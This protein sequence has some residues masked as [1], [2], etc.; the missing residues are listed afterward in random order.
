MINNAHFD[1][2]GKRKIWYAISV[3]VIIAGIISL[4]IQGLN[5]GLDFTGGNVIQIQF[6]E[7]VA[8]D[9]LRDV[10]NKY[11]DS[12]PTIQESDDNNYIIRT[13]EMDEETSNA[14]LEEIKSTFGNDE[15]LRNEKVGAVIGSELI[16]NA[17]WALIAAVILMLIYITVRFKFNFA[18]SAVVPLLHDVLITVGLFSILRVE[19]DSTFVAAILT[20]LGYS[21]NG[22][23]VIFDRIRE[24]MSKSAKTAFPELVNN[25]INQTLGRSINTNIAVLILVVCLLVLGGESTKSFALALLIGF[26]AGCYSSMFI[27]GPMLSDITHLTGGDK[28]YKVK[29]KK[30]KAIK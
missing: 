29:N 21:I 11:V 9:E 15:I 3:V 1:F 23:I 8:I 17:K 22:T 26:V 2:V 25:S 24:N 28:Q 12:T 6:E 30:V 27:A 16:S 7:D 20:I 10:V 5:F 13:Q 18:V 14:M 19:V 4:C